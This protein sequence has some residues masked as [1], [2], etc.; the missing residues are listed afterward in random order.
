[1]I[2]ISPSAL[3]NCSVRKRQPSHVH[4]L[5]W[6][7]RDSVEGQREACDRWRTVDSIEGPKLIATDIPGSS[8][9]SHSIDAP[10]EVEEFALALS[11]QDGRHLTEHGRIGA[12]LE[13]PRLALVV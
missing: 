2:A 6:Q 3:K 8:A 5:T 7:L 10:V 1:M 11:L 12:A 4:T 9:H 13:R